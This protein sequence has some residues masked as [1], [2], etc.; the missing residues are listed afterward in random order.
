MAIISNLAAKFT[1][2]NAIRL[3]CF[4]G[5]VALFF[6]IVQSCQKPKVG[7]KF[8]ATGGIKALTVLDAPPP[9]PR[10]TFTDADGETMTLADYQGKVILVN[11]WATWCPPCVVEMPMLNDLQAQRGGRDFQV[12]N[13][14]LDRTAEEA[15]AYLI[16]KELTNLRDWHDGTYKLPSALKVPGL[17][18]TILYDRNGREVARL[19]GEADW[20]SPDALRLIDTLTQ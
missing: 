13:I 5:V 9:Q 12:I 19:S 1:L 4:I 3:M 15:R 2:S 20:V 6:V 14:S 11:V 17:P 16:E 7:L 18:V 8:Y 10:L